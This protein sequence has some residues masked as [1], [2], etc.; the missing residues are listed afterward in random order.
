[1]N[2]TN[3]YGSNQ[4]RR[5]EQLNKRLL[6]DAGHTGNYPMMDVTPRILQEE[7]KSIKERIGTFEANYALKKALGRTEPKEWRIY[8]NV[9][10]GVLI[11]GLISAIYYCW[12]NNIY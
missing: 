6:E 2:T 8:T 10:Y 5:R 11:I 3:S 7:V 9:I 4:A 1:M 12:I